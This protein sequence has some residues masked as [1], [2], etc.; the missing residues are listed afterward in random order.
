MDMKNLIPWSRSKSTPAF[1]IEDDGTP[2]LALHREMNRLFDDFFRGFDLPLGQANWSNS[3]PQLD[4]VDN[5]KDVKITAE[6]P[7]LDEKD[8]ELTLRDGIL[9][10]KGEKKTETDGPQYSER[11][12]G[13]FQRSLQ[14]GPDINPDT[15]SASFKNGLLTVTVEKK[16]ETQRSTKHIP[17]NA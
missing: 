7:G 11:W 10:L 4:V 9:T 2:F 8:V 3:W 15:V 16:P 1:R 14:L 5:T 17:I 13:S 12:H 6:L